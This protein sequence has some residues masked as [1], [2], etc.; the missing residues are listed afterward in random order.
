MRKVAITIHA[1]SEDKVPKEALRYGQRVSLTDD[2]ATEEI[3]E[4]FDG[5]LVKYGLEIVFTEPKECDFGLVRVE[6]RQ[7]AETR[8]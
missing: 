3:L 4:I 5:E 6:P 2:H 8:G 1:T 7:K